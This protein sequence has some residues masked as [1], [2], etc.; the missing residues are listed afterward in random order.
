MTFADSA[1]RMTDIQDQYLDIQ[2]CDNHIIY[3]IGIS[4]YSALISEI[5]ILTYFNISNSA[6]LKILLTLITQKTKLALIQRNFFFDRISKK[7]FF[8]SKKL[9]SQCKL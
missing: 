5:F 2:L 6:L 3:S 8:D 1:R 9:F 7:C 4:K